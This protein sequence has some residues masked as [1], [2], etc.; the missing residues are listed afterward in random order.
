MNVCDNIDS[1]IQ[2]AARAERSDVSR[3]RFDWRVA[4]SR[5]RGANQ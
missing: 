4:I 3:A 1:K 5:R 2:I